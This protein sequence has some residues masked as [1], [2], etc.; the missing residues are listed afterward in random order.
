ME[1]HDTLRI[2]VLMGGVSNEREISLKSGRAVLEGLR[3]AGHDAVPYDVTDRRLDG[4]A[5]LNADA[6]FVALHGA[7]GE[8]G[9]VQNILERMA[10]PYTGSGPR[11]SRLGMDKAASKNVFVRH[12]IPT[13]DYLVAQPGADPADIARHTEQLG[14]PVVCKP[15]TGGSSIGVSIVRA[16]DRLAGAVR[17][18]REH[19]EAVLIER[20]VPGRELT[21]GVLEGQ[22]LPV[23][24]MT[25]SRPFFDYQAKYSDESTCYITP[26][27]LL[28]TI[29]RK[30]CGAA[31]R[32]YRA[33]GCRHMARVDM[34]HGY[35]GSLNVLEL[36]TIPGFTP[37]S[38]LP[39][40]AAEAGIGF[41]ELCDRIVRATMRD[42]RLAADRRRMTA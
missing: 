37:R 33:V 25:M 30:A 13:A 23:I 7:F 34:I 8:D 22:A 27:A 5:A 21:V 24:E 16:P 35:D 20:Y 28:P 18:A 38:L 11:A 14:Y 4:L 6:A 10:I 15:S 9:T 19:S 40:A 26:V 1:R 32:A 36:N 3:R 17:Q 42:A 2:A 12:A 31:E 29:Y 41:A 39:M